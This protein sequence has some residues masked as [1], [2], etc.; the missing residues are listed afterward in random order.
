[1]NN[2]LRTLPLAQLKR[3]AAIREQ[4]ER[5]ESE[6]NKL[7]SN[8]A[9]NVTTKQKRGKRSAATRARMSAA[10]KARWARIKAGKA[11]R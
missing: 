2:P 1:M 4:I 3:A 6:I 11:K 8:G 5:L 7:V 10:H 9:P